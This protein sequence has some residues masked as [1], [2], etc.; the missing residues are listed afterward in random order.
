LADAVV[1]HEHHLTGRTFVR[2]HWRYGAD[3][4]S[5]HRRRR[6]R[7]DRAAEVRL[8]FYTGLLRYPFREHSPGAA[9][10]LGALMALSQGAYAL[11]VL[12]RLVG[13]Q[14]PAGDVAFER[15]S[16]ARRD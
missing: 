15:S 5:V 1:Y 12:R 13:D 11:G 3:S 2:Q 6:A 10:R 14:F 4:V 16:M 9:A 8:S 7:G